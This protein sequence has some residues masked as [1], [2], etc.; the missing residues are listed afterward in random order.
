MK[1]C[2]IK[3]KNWNP[4]WGKNWEFIVR[5]ANEDGAR[6]LVKNATSDI[7][8]GSNENEPKWDSSAWLNEDLT[9]CDVWSDD[10]FA[11]SGNEEILWP[12]DNQWKQWDLWTKWS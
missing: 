3:P 10:R 5:A 1:I 2:K 8:W 11:L 9:V 7:N 12:E 6:T 4:T